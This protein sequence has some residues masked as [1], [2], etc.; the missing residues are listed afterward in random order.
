MYA[1]AV[2]QV[3]YAWAV[4]LGGSEGA[5]LLQRL[6]LADGA[7]EYAMEVGAFAHAFQLAEGAAKE[8]LSDVHLKYAM[9]LEDAGR[10]AEAEQEFLNAGGWGLHAGVK[11]GRKQVG[12]FSATRCL[13]FVVNGYVSLPDGWNG[14]ASAC[15]SVW[16]NFNSSACT[17]VVCVVVLQGSRRRRLTCTPT[18]RTGRRPCAWRSSMTRRLCRTSS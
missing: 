14:R 4:E 10:F 1:S 8:K 12:L 9:F 3:A 7:V 17:C 5:V 2:L 11:V 16:A 6:G 18:T 15:A 13:T